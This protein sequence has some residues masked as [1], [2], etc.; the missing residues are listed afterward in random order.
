M[1]KLPYMILIF[2]AGVCW[3]L[4]AAVNAE[5]KNRSGQ[6]LAA[7]MVNGGGAAILAGI[8]LVVLGL[9]WGKL[10]VPTLASMQAVPW[11]AYL[12]GVISV[13][14]IVAQSTSAVP[15]GAALLITLFVAGQGLSSLVF[16]QFGLLGFVPRSATPMRVMGV[17]LLMAGAVALAIDGQRG[18]KA[19]APASS[20]DDR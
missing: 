15:L 6:P 9:W 18:D 7:V 19:P 2:A 8:G 14:V 16:D 10:H 3:P 5:L 11:W 20:L 13:L 12:G 17:G 4:Q 1:N